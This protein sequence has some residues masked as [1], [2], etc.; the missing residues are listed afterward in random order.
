MDDRRPAILFEEKIAAWRSPRGYVAN[1]AAAIALSATSERAAGQIYNVAESDSFSE[2]EWALQVAAAA[3]WDGNFITLPADRTPPH[4]RF[5]GNADQHWVVDTTRIRQELGYR[6]P[7]AR[8][9]AIRRSV[10][11]ERANPAPADPRAFDYAAEDG[12]ISA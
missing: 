1:V 9:D 3:G 4:L 2:L 11:W 12:A 5:P 10:E 6:E 7:V 8:A